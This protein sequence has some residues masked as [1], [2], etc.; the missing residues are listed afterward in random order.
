LIFHDVPI[1]YSEWLAQADTLAAY[2]QAR[3][4]VATGDRVVFY[5]QNCPQFVVAYYAIMRADAVAVPA[6]RNR[7]SA[8][9]TNARVLY[10]V[11][12]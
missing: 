2:L 3:C 1:T 9:D 11:F 12:P 6:R 10:S 4:G 8:Q 7:A 5:M